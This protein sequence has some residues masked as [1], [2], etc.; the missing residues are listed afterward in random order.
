M[1][2]TNHPMAKKIAFWPL[3]ALQPYDKNP[4]IHSEAQVKQIAASIIEFGFNN[5]ILVD[6]EKSIVA[7]HGRLEAARQL[8]LDKIPVIQL[9]HLTPAQQRAYR[10]AD[11]KLTEN[12]EWDFDLLAQELRDLEV[13]E[14]DIA[15]TG[16]DWD[17]L[18]HAEG[19]NEPEV[20]P[21]KQ[22][23]VE[24]EEA[25][26]APTQPVSQLGDMWLLGNH[27]VLC[28]DATDTAALDHLL[29][30]AQVDLIFTDPPY[31]VD[32]EGYTADKLT[33]QND[34]QSPKEFKHFLNATFA[35]CKRALKPTG[36]LYVCH[37]SSYQREFQN[38]LEANDFEVRTQII[39]AKHHFAWG[40]G[41]YKFQHEP[42]FY[43]HHKGQA[44]VWYGDKSQSTLWQIDKPT[45]NRL[46]PTMKPIALIEVALKNSTRQ[47]DIVLDL[48]G[49]SG[50]TLIAA[51]KHHRQCFTM[52]LDPRYVDVIVTRWQEW[53][54]QQAILAGSK[55]SF[56]SVR[57]ERL[58]MGQP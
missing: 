22:G 37:G 16:F 26:K 48:F 46:H 44:D 49:G 17:E 10:I 24:D 13:D 6:Q 43:G 27:R 41:R 53:S 15:L 14:F 28:G 52:E 23:Q 18:D 21:A 45:A 40:H 1:S 30:G 55:T 12:G 9:D 58:V 2:I 19:N 5:P 39:W 35:A 42:I 54:G 25:P 7:G 29:D 38:A 11:N 3:S 50:S 36:S 47:N 20:V 57:R 33:L 8:G 31:N 32:Y 34:K 4:R 56:D 51:D